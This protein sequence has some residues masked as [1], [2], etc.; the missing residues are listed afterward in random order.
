LLSAHRLELDALV[1]LLLEKQVVSGDE[2]YEM[3]GVPK[4]GI[5][6]SLIA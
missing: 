1:K 5:Q 4:P 3:C 2:V 6:F